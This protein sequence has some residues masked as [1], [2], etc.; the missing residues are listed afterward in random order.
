M[1]IVGEWKPAGEFNIDNYK[2]GDNFLVY[3]RELIPIQA[4]I[5]LSYNHKFDSWSKSLFRF[6]ASGDL[7][8]VDFEFISHFAKINPP[9]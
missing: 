6:D 4:T 7:I 3:Y 8:E 9:C 5:D 1:S 2:K